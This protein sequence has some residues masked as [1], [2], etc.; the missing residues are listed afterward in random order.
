VSSDLARFVPARHHP[1]EAEILQ[2][3]NAGLSNADIAEQL[4]ISVRT[5]ESHVS[6]M[7]SFGGEHPMGQLDHGRIDGEDVGKP[8]IKVL[9]TAMERRLRAPAGRSYGIKRQPDG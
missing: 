1:R 6:S 3:V 8:M 4:A 5:V 7:P 9:V 2:L